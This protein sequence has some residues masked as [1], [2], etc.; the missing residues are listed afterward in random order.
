MTPEEKGE[1]GEQDL[2]GG[3]DMDLEGLDRQGIDDT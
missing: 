2:K 1:Q 3:E